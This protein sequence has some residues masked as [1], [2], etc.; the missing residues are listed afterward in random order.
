TGKN[1]ALLGVG[2]TGAQLARMAHAFGMQV[3]AS[4]RNLTNL[5]GADAYIHATWPLSDMQTM[6]ARAD[7]VS[8]HLPLND[9]TRGTIG[10]KVFGAMTPSAFF[11]NIARGEIVDKAALLTAL[12]ERR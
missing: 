7:Y 10:D 8:L 11:I 12:A 6:L 5:D 4:K 9:R 1:L 2:G 3:L